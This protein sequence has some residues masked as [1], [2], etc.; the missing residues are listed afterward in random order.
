MNMTPEMKVKEASSC[1]T[2]CV[3]WGIAS[4]SKAPNDEIIKINDSLDTFCKFA[5]GWRWR[6]RWRVRNAFQNNILKIADGDFK[7][8]VRT[9][10]SK[11]QNTSNVMIQSRYILSLYSCIYILILQF[12]LSRCGWTSFSLSLCSFM[13]VSGRSPV[14][15]HCQKKVSLMTC[16]NPLMWFGRH[17]CQRTFLYWSLIDIALFI[18]SPASQATDKTSWNNPFIPSTLCS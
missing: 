9:R 16:N 18:P 5:T 2:T 14:S 17:Y 11:L 10:Y 8:R 12:F 4:R 13:L 1:I 6:C 7:M 3:H 15:L